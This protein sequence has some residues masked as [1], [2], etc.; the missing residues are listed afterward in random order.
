MDATGPAAGTAHALDELGANA[1][2]A[3]VAGFEMLS[4]LGPANPFVAGQRRDVA[5][6]QERVGAGKQRQANI[7]RQSMDGASEN[8]LTEIYGLHTYIVKY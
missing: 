2:D 7:S 3:A 5:P 6:G 1:A 4:G 8:F